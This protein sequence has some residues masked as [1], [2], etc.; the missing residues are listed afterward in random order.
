[1]LGRRHPCR[2]ALLEGNLAHQRRIGK[3]TVSGGVVVATSTTTLP[4]Q[5]GV[6]LT[7][8]SLDFGVMKIGIGRAF[9]IGTNASAGNVLVGKQWV[10]VGG[11]QILVE[12][13]PVNELNPIG[14]SAWFCIGLAQNFNGRLMR[15]GLLGIAQ[16]F[17][18]MERKVEV[19][20]AAEKT[21]LPKIILPS[22]TE[23][24]ISR[25]RSSHCPHA[26][27]W[28]VIEQPAEITGRSDDGSFLPPPLNYV[29]K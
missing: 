4:A 17:H 1:M 7:D 22:P 13:V 14:E 5:A 21:A 26:L 19:T 16:R 23:K 18:A 9:M 2:A 11:R 6:S 28:F 27:T 15:I 8:E 12:E 25:L 20:H 24:R 3:V 29:N 10:Q